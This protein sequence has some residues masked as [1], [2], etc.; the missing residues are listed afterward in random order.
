MD[1][2]NQN[3]LY[4]IWG[5]RVTKHTVDFASHSMHFE[6]YANNDGREV[7]T[8]NDIY[9]VR[10]FCYG[11]D[12]CCQDIKTFGEDGGLFPTPPDYT[13]IV[14]RVLFPEL[15]TTSRGF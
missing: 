11:N 2:L 8:Q 1:D 12:T 15:P 14:F 6:L 13:G 4:P 9:N 10:M 3:Y 5:S 7:R